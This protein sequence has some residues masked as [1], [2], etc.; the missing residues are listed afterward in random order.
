MVGFQVA[1]DGPAGAGKSSVAQG[2]ARILTVAYIDS[3]AM[4][5]SVTYM[6]LKHG[7]PADDEQAL[8][9]LVSDITIEFTM[10][11]GVQRIFV[12]DH[13]VTEQIRSP[14][15]SQHVAQ[16][17]KSPVVRKHLVH[18]SQQLA[19]SSIGVVMDGRDIG[20]HVLPDADVK[21]FLTATLEQRAK[22]RYDELA[23]KGYA[24]SLE[25]LISDVAARDKLDEQ[26]SMSPLRPAKDAIILDTSCLTYEEVIAMV[27][28][29][30][31]MREQQ[32]EGR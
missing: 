13:D 20:T 3:G 17:A 4:Y 24:P 12:G 5:R 16:I 21:F 6:A 31:R 27:S 10:V 23:A 15:V 11:N 18:L 7:V 32:K 29:L 2:L 28:A 9:Q 22:R 26:R 8:Q 25:D 19:K 1:I 14:Q 30:C